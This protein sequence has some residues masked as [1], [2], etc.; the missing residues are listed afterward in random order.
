MFSR[1]SFFLLSLLGAMPKLVFRGGSGRSQENK[2][3][4]L[5]QVSDLG[6]TTFP[7]RRKLLRARPRGPAS[8]SM[9][10]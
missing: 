3:F 5:M 2:R 10:G 7:I 8:F 4:N 6:D 9:G 1:S